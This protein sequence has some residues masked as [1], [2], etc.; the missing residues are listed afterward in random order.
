[1]DHPEPPVAPSRD[2]LSL[3]PSRSSW[4]LGLGSNTFCPPC[5]DPVPPMEFFGSD[6]PG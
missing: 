1:M 5:D 3:K 6:D 2:N 4:F